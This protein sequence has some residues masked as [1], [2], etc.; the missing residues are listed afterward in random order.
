MGVLITEAFRL[1][2]TGISMT[3]RYSKACHS[4]LGPPLFLR[5]ETSILPRNFQSC[6]DHLLAAPS[7]LSS[8][9]LREKQRACQVSFRWLRD[10]ESIQ[11]Y[12]AGSITS[13][14]GG[15]LITS[16]MG[17]SRILTQILPFGSPCKVC[18]QLKFDNAQP[19]KMTSSRHGASNAG[20]QVSKSSKCASS[21][22]LNPEHL[23]QHGRPSTETC[24]L[25]W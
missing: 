14:V 13:L 10:S 22:Y 20:L 2:R 4:R 23:V 12:Q 19:L 21:K 9:L 6:H 8:S 15:S 25:C 1:H 24:G 7:A 16:S 17:R 3:P 11:A 5:R 18:I